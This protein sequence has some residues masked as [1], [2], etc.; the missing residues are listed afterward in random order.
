[1][2]NVSLSNCQNEWE[3]SSSFIS[4]EFGT[5]RILLHDA[6]GNKVSGATRGHEFNASQFKIMFQKYGHHETHTSNASPIT[7]KVTP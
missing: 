3:R 1:M 5:L 6:Y 4:Q 7:L 2:V